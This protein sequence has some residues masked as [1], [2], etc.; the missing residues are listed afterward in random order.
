MTNYLVM[1]KNMPEHYFY[2]SGIYMKR[3]LTSGIW[4]EPVPVFSGGRDG[5]GIY[6]SNDKNVHL[7]CSDYGGNLIYAVSSGDEWKKYVIS[8]LAGDISVSDMCLYSICGRLNLMYSAIYGGENLL[9]HCILGDHAKPS[10]V[11]SLESPHFFIKGTKVYYT[12]TIGVFGFVSLS[13]EKPSEFTPIYKNAHFGTV[14]DIDGRERVLFSRDSSVFL[15]GTEIAC[16]THVEAPILAKIRDKFYVMWKNGG[17][18]RYVTSPD[19]ENFTRP[20]R[21]MNTGKAMDIFTVQ[22]GNDFSY[23]Y[24]YG[25]QKGPALLGSPDIFEVSAN[26]R[27][28][29]PSELEKVKNM[30]NK[31]QKDVTDAKKEIARLGKILGSL[32]E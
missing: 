6:C 17:F 15:D 30:L 26:Y 23:Y 7:I 14:Y 22:K 25:T 4:Q 2:K 20:M 13:D 12:N 11:D 19:C 3:R 5:F 21:F 28:S 31:T 16:D 10:A 29:A 24:G 27:A 9:I 8:K 1:P 18:V 32:N